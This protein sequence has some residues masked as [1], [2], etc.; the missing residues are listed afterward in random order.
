MDEGFL[1]GPVRGK[2]GAVA[3][4]PT[5]TRRAGDLPDDAL[6]SPPARRISTRRWRDPRL[7]VGG[8]LV[9]A[10]VLVGASVLRA[11]DATVAVWAADA[12][13]SAG[14][15]ITAGDVRSVDVRLEGAEDGHYLPASSPVPQGAV[16]RH[17]VAAGELLAASAITRGRPVAPQLPLGVAAA[18]RPADLSAGDHVDVWSVP[19]QSARSRT[20]R[21]LQDVAV[22]AVGA[23]GPGRLDAES[24]V[25]VSLPAGADVARVLTLLRDATVVLV[26]VDG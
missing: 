23:A 25:L 8:L 13:L 12:D 9:C 1:A 16:L 14:S 15:E 20:T 4:A 18:G 19:E 17:D 2:N 3:F 21:V 7:W 26:R 22:V 6:G 5:P 10:S 24:E 11:A